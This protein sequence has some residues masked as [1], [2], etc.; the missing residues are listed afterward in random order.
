M[1]KIHYTNSGL[2]ENGTFSVNIPSVELVKQ[3]DYRGL[4]SQ[5]GVQSG[6]GLGPRTSTDKTV[7][8]K[9]SQFKT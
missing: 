1:G 2:R 4:V 5:S 8:R 9:N 3:T 6:S 7:A